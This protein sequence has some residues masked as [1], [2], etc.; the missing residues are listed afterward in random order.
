VE[1]PSSLVQ[2][3]RVLRH[4]GGVVRLSAL[5]TLLL[6]ALD[7]RAAIAGPG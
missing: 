2:L 5:R 3:E 6:G 1:R 7:R 4:L